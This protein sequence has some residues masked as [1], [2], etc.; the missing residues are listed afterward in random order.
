MGGRNVALIARVT[1]LL[2]ASR[3]SG[4]PNDPSVAIFRA[5]SRRAGRS[6]L[7]SRMCLASMPSRHA[8][9]GSASS[10]TFERVRRP[11][12][13]ALTPS[14]HTSIARSGV[15]VDTMEKFVPASRS[16]CGTAAPLPPSCPSAAARAASTRPC[17]SPASARAWRTWDGS[18]PWSRTAHQRGLRVADA[19]HRRDPTH[20]LVLPVT[21]RDRPFG[22][23]T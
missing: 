9:I 17:G 15:L 20:A 18:F 1:C 5:E 8:F 22:Q 21:K 19:V 14:R 2:A 3:R 4:Q 6:T 13:V 16:G 12:M 10:S 7:A 23:E 11:P